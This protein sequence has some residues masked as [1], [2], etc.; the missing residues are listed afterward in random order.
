LWFNAVMQNTATIEHIG[1]IYHALAPVMDERMRRQWAAA[2]A[3][4]RYDNAS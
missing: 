2:E 4:V 3:K 1:S